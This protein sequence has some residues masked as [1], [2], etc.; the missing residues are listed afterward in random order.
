[1]LPGGENIIPAE[2]E[3][4]LLAH[5][6]I[7]EVS[8]VG[9]PDDK[10][11]EA[12]ACFVRQAEKSARLSAAHVADWVHQTLGRHKA[13]NHVFWIGDAAVGEDFPKTGSGKHQK[14]ILRA[15]GA[16]LLRQNKDSN[17][18]AVRARL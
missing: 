16:R 10:Y 9:V 1:M 17:E 14:H 6:S 4:R 3:E 2:I 11:G 7:V 8:V 12:V 13:P 15:M 18:S 5:A